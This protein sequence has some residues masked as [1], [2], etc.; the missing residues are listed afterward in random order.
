MDHYDALYGIIVFR[1]V[2]TG[3]YRLIA[4]AATPME[5]FYSV[6]IRELPTVLHVS[7]ALE[8]TDLPVNGS[9]ERSYDLTLTAGR[10]YIID[11]DSA[12][13]DAFVKLQ[14][15]DGAIVA[16][17]DECGAMRTARMVFEPT[18]T[19]TYRVVATSYIDRATGPFRLIVCE[20]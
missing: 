20:D 18:Q 8:S 5:G 2:T 10:R 15:A 16:F 17:E 3:R 6:T 7:D 13:F 9:F 12:H 1:P 4:N 19:A 11:M 14:N